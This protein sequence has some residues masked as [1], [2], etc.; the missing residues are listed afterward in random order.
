MI[1]SILGRWRKART[2]V[3]A[4][5][6][7]PPRATAV[8]HAARPAPA[9][10]PVVRP[11]LKRNINIAFHPSLIEELEADHAALLVVYGELGSAV[12]RAQWDQVGPML[13]KLRSMLTDHLLKEGV[14]LYCYLQGVFAD[15]DDVSSLFRHFKTEMGGIGKVAFAFV[16]RYAAAGALKTPTAQAA[17]AEEY[18]TIGK[19]LVDRIEREEKQLYPLYNSSGSIFA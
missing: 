15:D 18:A 16:D 3:S 8:P 1:G 14:K 2:R 5:P 6:T 19:V 9:P 13:I 12:E 7:M 11:M 4:T 10:R 17:F